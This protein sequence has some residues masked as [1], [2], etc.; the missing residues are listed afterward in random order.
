MRLTMNRRIS[1]VL[2]DMDG[3]LVDSEPAYWESD[4]EFLGRYGI[5]YDEEL[6][7]TFIG[8][9]SVE[10]FRSLES[11]FPDSPVNAMSLDER[12]RLKDEAFALYAPSR[13]LPFPAVER[14]ARS[15]VERGVFIAVASGSSRSV[16]DLM[17][18]ATGLGGLFPLRV[19][20]SEVARGKP[21][22]D[23][24]LETARRAGVGP[25]NCLVLED[26]RFGVAAAKAAGMACIAMPC[27]GS[28]VH[29]DFAAADFVVE[30]GAACLDPDLVLSAF[31][32]ATESSLA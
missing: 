32:W 28:P 9:G 25:G 1:A 12:V 16:I 6:N 18:E 26:S 7:S 11:L 21:E 29:A 24:F 31:D 8:R 22:P 27:P 13:V 2:F 30:G 3:T 23:V 19:S 20:A 17:L 14:L 15:L 10:M 5:D 4:R